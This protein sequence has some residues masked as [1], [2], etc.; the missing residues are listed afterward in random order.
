[1]IFILCILVNTLFSLQTVGAEKNLDSNL[2]HKTALPVFKIQH[3]SEPSS[4]DP[5]KQKSASSNYLMGNLFRNIYKYEDEKGLISDLGESCSRSKM[6]LTCKIKKNLQWSDGTPLTSEDFLRTYKKI[7]N[8]DSLIPRAD[9]LF[10]IK[11]AQGIFKQQKK[12]ETLGITNPDPWTLKFEFEEVDSEFE[13]NL[14]NFILAPTKVDLNVFSGPYKIKE[15]KKG[16]KIILEPNFFYKAGHPNRPP[17]EY[18]FISEDAVALQLYEKNELQFLRR[19]PTIFIPKYKTR[20]DFHWIPVIRLDYVGFG[21]ELS[22][23][24]HEG[25]RKAFI[26]SLNY[27][28]LQKIFLSEGRPGCIGLPDSWFPVKAPCYDFDLKKVKHAKKTKAYTFQFSALGGEDHKRGTEWMQDQWQKNAGLT[29]HL[30]AKENK[31]FLAGLQKEPPALFRKG[32]PLDKPTCLSALSTFSMK[33]PE[34][35]I[36]FQSL[37]LEKNLDLM[38][39][40]AVPEIKKKLCL[41]GI[42]LLINQHVMIPM[43]PIHFST[44]VKPTFLGWKINQMNQLDLSDLHFQP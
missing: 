18:L 44:L 5:Q 41:R 25:L 38:E 35:Y 30:E 24:N 39:G 9:L 29:V 1:M 15:W 23:P 4:L 7:L 6:I 20:K 22:T 36:R 21:P 34:N 13:Y 10:K 42:D 31:V 11:N 3:I 26:Y 37:E 40:S 28:E 2:D 12:P 14:A 32:T 27:P 8:P 33:N 17:V 19:L 43:G 16:E